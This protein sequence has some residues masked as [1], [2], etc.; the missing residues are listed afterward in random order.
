MSQAVTRTIRKILTIPW[1]ITTP[2]R[3]P[4]ARKFDEHVARIVALGVSSIPARLD[5]LSGSLERIETS[6]AVGRQVVEHQNA[7]ANMLLDSVIRELARLQ[8]Q[9]DELREVVHKDSTDGGL[10]LVDDTSASD[11]LAG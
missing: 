6:I 5:Q 8:L 1:R 11:R 10:S 7:D 4:V 2:L 3:R 9:I